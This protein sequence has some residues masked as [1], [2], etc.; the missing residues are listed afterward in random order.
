MQLKD[1][2]VNKGYFQL[3]G[4]NVRLGTNSGNSTGD[5]I[6]RMNGSDRIG[7]DNA[8][9]M[10]IGTTSPTS[11]LHVAGR[12]LFK[13]SGEVIAVDGTGNPNIGFYSNGTFKSF[14][15]QSPSELYIG[16][17]GGPLHLDATQIAI[18]GVVS[19]STAYKLAVNGK[20]ICEEVKV[21]LVS[22]GWPDYV[23]GNEY[24]LQPLQEVEKFI[25]TN[26]HL[27]N[28]PSAAEVEKNGIEIAD[29]QKRTMEKVEELTL[30]I[31]D[32]QKQ[33]T[34]LK[35]KEAARNN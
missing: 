10:G 29:M 26:K 20:I 31:I 15:S 33:I 22:S 21:K 9:N 25:Q 17:N 2:G 32:L 1:G 28:I 11:K 34:D 24:K 19:G 13:G 18:G 5:L 23:F 3:S 14:I 27:P 35:A 12:G 16:V 30:Y 7:I 8:G 6:I 4:D